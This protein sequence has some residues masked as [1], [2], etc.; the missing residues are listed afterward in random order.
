M[1]GYLIVR[2][3]VADPQ[4]YERYR[5]VVAPLI[6]RHGGRYLVRGGDSETL[7]GADNRFRIIVVEFPSLQAAKAFWNSPDYAAAK[8]LRE[9]AGQLEAIAVE[10]V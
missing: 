6:E 10:G 9:G 5:K 3:A 2:V 8:R 4:R 7:E 1:A